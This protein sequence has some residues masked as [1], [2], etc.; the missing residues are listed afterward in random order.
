VT[1][2]PPRLMLISHS[3]EVGGAEV[4]L[5]KLVRYLAEAD[6]DRRWRSTLVCRRDK[7][8]DS[9]AAE[10]SKSCEVARLDVL[11][12]RDV[13][14]LAKLVR[15]SDLVHLNLSFPSGKYQFAAA[16]ITQLL[17]RPLV[18]THHLALKVSAR[19]RVAMRWLGRAARSHIAVS[20]RSRNVLIQE[21]GY[22]PERVV[23][24]HNGIDTDRFKPA[25]EEARR[26]IRRTGGENLDGR[27]WGDDVLL[28]CTV[29][30]LSTQKGLFELIEATAIVVKQV[31][32][33][34]VVVI[35]EG[36]LRRRLV[37]H[38]RALGVE[39]YF[40]LAGAMPHERVADWLA[41]ADLFV[42]PSHYEG[43]PATALMEAMACGCAVVTTD[44][45]GV[46][47]IIADATLGTVVPPRDAN[48]LAAAI[49][50]LLTNPAKRAGMAERGRAKV[51]A[52]FT[53][54]ASLQ[55]TFAVFDAAVGGELTAP[56]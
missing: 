37:E 9:W 38:I 34:R 6:G 27:P 28:A 55:R 56:A 1:I 53:I 39:R 24:V 33:A 25:T 11:N 54:A 22:P 44:V 23:V 52:D 51:N 21:F 45:S 50:D 46:E 2:A 19:W 8:L 13:R 32:Q 42:L 16:L 30:R 14:E 31:P 40:F 49:T 12:P 35:G 20:H 36:E 29:A 3:R 41:A 4:Y 47:E 43:G 26:E 10:I 15:Q 7:V 5:E 48:A 18:V 17:R